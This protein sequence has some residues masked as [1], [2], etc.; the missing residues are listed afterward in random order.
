MT[1][2]AYVPRRAP[3]S[4]FIPVR[5]LRYHVNLWGDLAAITPQR[6]LLVW[7]HG[8]MDVGASL[9]FVVD[10]LRDERAIAAPDWRGF[11]RTAPPPLADCYWFPDYLGD[12]DA[13]LDALS[14][15]APVDLAGHS[16]GGNV[17][18]TYAG[19]RP[20]RIR[21]LVNMEG[22]GLPEAAPEQ[23]PERLRQWLDELKTPQQI[24]PYDSL[25]AV[26]A[27]LMKNNPRLSR[28]RALWLAAHWA[29]QRDDGRW[30]VLGDPAHKRVNPVLY[31]KDEVLA[32]WRRIAASTLWVEGDETDPDR[33]W[34]HRYPRSEF[35]A[36]IAIVRDLQRVRLARCGHMLHFDQPDALA[37][38]LESF[39]DGA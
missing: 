7:M 3:H 28:D 14:P 36:R 25:D 17:V 26:A 37:A 35:D 19:A 31:R 5:T 22:F 9:Q 30:H 32:G 6:P 33:W 1:T 8:W 16:M 27:R 4:R 34:G 10:A 24:R 15:G 38:A 12:L 21:R 39:L 29:E 13:L 20:G 18:M 23:A 11:G 2:N